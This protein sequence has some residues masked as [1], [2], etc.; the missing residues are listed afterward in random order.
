MGSFLSLGIEHT[1]LLGVALDFETCAFQTRCRHKKAML[2]IGLEEQLPSFSQADVEADEPFH[3]MR[4]PHLAASEDP[5]CE[6]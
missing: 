2:G 1:R 4:R 6:R 3:W 5:H